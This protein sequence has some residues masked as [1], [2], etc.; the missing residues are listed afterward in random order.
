MAEGNGY[1]LADIAAAMGGNGGFG[2]MGGSWMAVLFLII[3]LGGGNG[4][5][6]GTS[7]GG[8]NSI[9]NLMTTIRANF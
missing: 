5:G 4:F 1:S 9:S 8:V 3:L 2:G 7:D 6:W